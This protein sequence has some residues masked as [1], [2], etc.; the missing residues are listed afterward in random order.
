MH[1]NSN[2][3]IKKMSYM[4]RIVDHMQEIAEGTITIDQ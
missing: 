1:K 2:V 3:N 4:Q